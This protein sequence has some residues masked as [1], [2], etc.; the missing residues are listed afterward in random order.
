MVKLIAPMLSLQAR[1]A[2]GK[3]LT[4]K[5]T[6]GRATCGRW[7]K[8][9][10][11]RTP[12]QISIRGFNRRLTAAWDTIMPQVKQ[13]WEPEAEARQIAPYHAYLSYNM[14]RW[15]Q[16]LAP[17]MFA[18]APGLMP[19]PAIN[20]SDVDIK[21]P[22]WITMWNW[23]AVGNIWNAVWYSV[24][25]GDPP[26]QRNSYLDAIS[27]WDSPVWGVHYYNHPIGHYDFYTWG[28][29]YDGDQTPMVGPMHRW[30][31]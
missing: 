24:P 13:T 3:A 2:L 5:Q 30:I 26:P 10:Y 14:K 28:Y 22:G 7:L 1:G 19:C 6:N 27:S 23:F 25:N 9:P 18:G 31:T 12:A 29:G 16:Q 11:R 21:A 4:F 8:P 20:M 15:N 17:S